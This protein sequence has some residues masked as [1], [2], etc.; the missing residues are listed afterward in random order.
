M[1][2]KA[3][4]LGCVT[5]VLV[6]AACGLNPQSQLA[7]ACQGYASALSTAALNKDQLTEQQIASVNTTRKAVNPICTD[8]QGVENYNDALRK[9]RQ[10]TRNLEAMETN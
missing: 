3:K 1:S 6:V 9:V 2:S 5:A 10:A 7:T 4:L 8:I